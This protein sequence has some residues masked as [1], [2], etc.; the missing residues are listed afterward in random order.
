MLRILIVDDEP[1]ICTALAIGLSSRDVEVDVATDG[2]NGIRLGMEKA[3]D[4][5]IVDLYINELNGIKIIS[6]LKQ[7]WMN[8]LYILITGT[9]D[10]AIYRT[11]KLCGVDICFEKP[12][13]AAQIVN[14]LENNGLMV[15]KSG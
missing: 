6:A 11:A 8:S 2:Y 7:K 4:A 9:P 3:Y 14:A 15:Y 12:V 1:S 5:I 10:D 13:S